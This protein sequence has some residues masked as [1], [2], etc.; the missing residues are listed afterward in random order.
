[1]RRQN[2]YVGALMGSEFAPCGKGERGL[3]LRKIR[4]ALG[5]NQRGTGEEFWGGLEDRIQGA[6]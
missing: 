3:R 6:G 2:R 5:G 1:M 4:A